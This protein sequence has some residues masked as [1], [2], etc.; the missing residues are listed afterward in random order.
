MKAVLGAFGEGTI[1]ENVRTAMHYRSGRGGAGEQSTFNHQPS[2]GGA[3]ARAVK[4]GVLMLLALF[5]V[6]RLGRRRGRQIGSSASHSMSDMYLRGQLSSKSSG[7]ANSNNEQTKSYDDNAIVHTAF[8][9][10]HLG[11]LANLTKP[12][13]AKKETPF[14]W[15]VHMSGE[16]VAEAVFAQCHGLVQACEFGLR[17]PNYDEDVSF[18]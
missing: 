12:Y 5:G 14:F 16:S 18:M 13:D 3:V 15:D 6:H 4:I 7:G 9:P 8:F 11:H 10:P 17:Q 1:G 2:K